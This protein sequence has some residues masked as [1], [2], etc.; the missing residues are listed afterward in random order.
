VAEVC[1]VLQSGFIE[2]REFV[3]AISVTSRG[4]MDEKLNCELWCCYFIGCLLC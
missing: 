4:S 1:D 3:H 2:F